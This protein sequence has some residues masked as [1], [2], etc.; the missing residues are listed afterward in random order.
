MSDR[1]LKVIAGLSGGVL[2]LWGAFMLLWAWI[3]DMLT[4]GFGYDLID[5]GFWGD[6]GLAGFFAQVPQGLQAF[7]VVVPLVALF[8]LAFSLLLLWQRHDKKKTPKE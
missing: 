1:G 3:K 8:A 5:L 2:A 4:G 6:S 7:A